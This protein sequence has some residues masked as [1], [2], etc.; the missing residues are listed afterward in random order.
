MERHRTDILILGSGGAG[1][2]AALAVTSEYTAGPP[3]LVVM[4]YGLWRLRGRGPP[5][6]GALVTAAA[7]VAAAALGGEAVKAF[8]VFFLRDR[9]DVGGL[10][11]PLQV[12]D[13]VLDLLIGHQGAVHA[14]D[15][16]A[17]GQVEHIALPQA[18][19]GARPTV[20]LMI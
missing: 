17:L 4:L 14:G 9:F 20:S 2:L 10:A 5:T 7:L 12:G 8:A 1:L 16:P 11:L 6:F 15:A 3:A 18:L 13:H 19:F